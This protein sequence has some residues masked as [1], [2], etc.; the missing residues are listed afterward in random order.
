MGCVSA[1]NG[2]RRCLTCAPTYADHMTGLGKNGVT[3]LT[4]CYEPL[5]GEAGLAASTPW[6]KFGEIG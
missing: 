2:V 1:S 4:L 5:R 6:L 3:V